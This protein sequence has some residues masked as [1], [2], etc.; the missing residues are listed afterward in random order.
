MSG[1]AAPTAHFPSAEYKFCAIFY[2]L[3]LADYAFSC[4]HEGNDYTVNPH[5]EHV[6]DNNQEQR[7][8]AA[9]AAVFFRA[10]AAELQ[11][12]RGEKAMLR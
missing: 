9:L 11:D 10:A 1:G 2:Y 6:H 4:Y 7:E 12:F 3:P 8:S 5:A